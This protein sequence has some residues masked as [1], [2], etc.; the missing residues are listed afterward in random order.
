M[1]DIRLD[2]TEIYTCPR[3]DCDP[4]ELV[5]MFCLKNDDFSNYCIAFLPERVR[6]RS[7]SKI[8]PFLNLS[9]QRR[10]PKGK[11]QPPLIV[12]PLNVQ[13]PIVK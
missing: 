3:C 12:L 8:C 10:H 7:L 4:Q 11:N 2:E 13:D 6:Q 5:F 1:D 9:P